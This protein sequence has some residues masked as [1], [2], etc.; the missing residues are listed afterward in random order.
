M[1]VR[2]YNRHESQVSRGRTTSN[3]AA[4]ASPNRTYRRIEM[5][6]VKSVNQ[7]SILASRNRT[8]DA[9][10]ESIVRGCVSVH[11]SVVN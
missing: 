1:N 5:R 10:G 4:L 8:E 6:M 2:K 9:F 11:M 7:G 3:A